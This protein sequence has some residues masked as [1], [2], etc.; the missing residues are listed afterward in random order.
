MVEVSYVIIK[1]RLDFRFK[2]KRGYFHF[3]TLIRYFAENSRG[4]KGDRPHYC[5]IYGL[6][7]KESSSKLREQR[8][9]ERTHYVFGV[10]G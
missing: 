7:T 5:S 6:M 3:V 1:T 4:P 8:S 10:Q 9:E 2:S